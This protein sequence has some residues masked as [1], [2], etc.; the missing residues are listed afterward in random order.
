MKN[1]ESANFSTSSGLVGSFKNSA[2]QV[3]L[4]QY[5]VKL[6]D[7]L[8]KEG[9]DIGWEQRGALHL[10]RHHDR[11]LQFRKMKTQSEAWMIKCELMSPDE[12]KQKCSIIS[13][14]D[15]IGGLFVKDDGIVD[16]EKLRKVLLQEAIKRGVTLVENCGV[17]R[18]LNSNRM[19]EAVETTHGTI[20]CIYFVNAAGKIIFNYL[21]ED[22]ANT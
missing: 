3:K 17:T 20:E 7:Q 1:L 6:L 12:C 21:F 2:P 11:M 16:K 22:I 13:D 5:S 18:I 19:V 10:A 8:T 4:G 9:F 14:K 15:L